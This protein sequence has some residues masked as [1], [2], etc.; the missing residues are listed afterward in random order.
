LFFQA[1]FI[2]QVSAMYHDA[3]IGNLINIVVVRI[4]TFEEG[5]VKEFI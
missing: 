5:Q 1:N 3:S 2:F 4:V